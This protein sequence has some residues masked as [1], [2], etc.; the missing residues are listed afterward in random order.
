MNLNS[1]TLIGHITQ[2]PVSRAFA[3]STKF[4]C[5]FTVATA[6]KKPK[7]KRSA[8]TEF[9]PV[10]AFGQLALACKDYLHKGRLVYITGRL[11]TNRWEDDNHVIHSKT[12]IYADEMLL[13]DKTQALLNAVSEREENEKCEECQA[14]PC[15]QE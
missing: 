14:T 4:L 2:D 7:G 13:L 3:D 5:K 15:A 10:V 1:V 6:G 8:E 12:E 11:H 9:H